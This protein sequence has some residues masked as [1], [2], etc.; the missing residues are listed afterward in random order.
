[1]ARDMTAEFKQFYADLMAEY[2][3]GKSPAFRAAYRRAAK[4]A[5]AN[6]RPY[7]CRDSASAHLRR[8]LIAARSA[9]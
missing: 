2:D 4:K 1:M 7:P 3:A 9:A 8:A 5:L 6:N